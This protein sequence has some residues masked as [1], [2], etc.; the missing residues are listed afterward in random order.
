MVRLERKLLIAVVIAAV[1]FLAVGKPHFTPDEAGY[2]VAVK[3]L[4]EGASLEELGLKNRVLHVFLLSVPARVF[5]FS[6]PMLEA[7]IFLFSLAAV[8]LVFLIARKIG[9]SEE[10]AFFA[11]VFFAI[12]PLAIV[13]SRGLLSEM[14]GLAFSLAAV[15]IYLQGKSWKSPVLSAV[16]AIAA[17]LIREY[18]LIAV[19]AFLVA[20]HAVNRKDAGQWKRLAAFIAAFVL[21]GVS[22]SALLGL[23]L[24]Y[25]YSENVK[26]VAQFS[27]SVLPKFLMIPF[28]VALGGA[29]AVLLAAYAFFRGSKNSL[30]L[31]WLSLAIIAMVAIPR[32]EVRYALPALVPLSILAGEAAEKI[33]GNKA[34]LA[35]LILAS[36]AASYAFSS[37]WNVKNDP[38]VFSEMTAFAISNG[39]SAIVSRLCSNYEIASGGKIA[40]KC[41]DDVKSI[42]ET[43]LF[44]EH[45]NHKVRPE[46]M[47]DCTLREIFRKDDTWLVVKRT[48]IA[49]EVECAS[50]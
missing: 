35:V 25:A 14:P 2:A 50:A 23:D 26:Y 15:F 17:F 41:T 28:S 24:L 44:I 8:A 16:F 39:N 22:S 30:V 48:T 9:A 40:V 33:K 29:S 34:I 18:I 21:L 46:W 3:N 38:A 12:S 5:G 27:D 32:V 43:E 20:F 1:V 19:G 13:L 10:A 45:S 4:S 42:S 31:L 47:S 11:S 37:Y 6:V 49:Y 36:L 7:M